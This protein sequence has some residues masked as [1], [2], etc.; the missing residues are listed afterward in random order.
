MLCL[1]LSA[2]SG[3]KAIIIG[4]GVVDCTKNGYIETINV[5]SLGVD[6]LCGDIFQIGVGKHKYLYK[7]INMEQIIKDNMT[8]NV[9]LIMIDNDNIK[10]M[11][12]K[13]EECFNNYF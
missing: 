4:I 6:V 12:I 2:C 5:D 1:L 13:N 3:S 10:T 11:E 9:D 7:S 8:N